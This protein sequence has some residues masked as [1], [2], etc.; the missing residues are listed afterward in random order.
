MRLYI[1]GPISIDPHF[2]E[3]FSAAETELVERGY[4][5]LN[6][7]R[8]SIAFPLLTEKEYMRLS[9]DLIGMAHGIYMLD[10][11]EMSEGAKAEFALAKKYGI[12]VFY[13]TPDSEHQ[14]PNVD[15]VVKK[16]DDGTG[17]VGSVPFGEENG[18]EIQ[19]PIQHMWR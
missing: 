13:E 16:W 2:P 1:S 6:P 7:A 5:V 4:V 11:W 3:R 9:I 15:V 19:I 17:V 10:G 18:R 8:L 14:N 12:P